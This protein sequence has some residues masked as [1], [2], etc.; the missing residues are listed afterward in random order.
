MQHIFFL[1]VANA[2]DHIA[3][4]N[5][6]HNI[7]SSSGIGFRLIS[8]KIYSFNGRLDFALYTSGTSSTS[9]S[10]GTQHFFEQQTVDLMTFTFT[11]MR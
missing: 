8:P 6:T 5:N 7:V 1:D 4:L 10:L 9:I 11:G 2:A 3:D